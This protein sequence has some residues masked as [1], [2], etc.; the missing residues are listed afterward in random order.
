MVPPATG[1]EVLSVGFSSSTERARRRGCLSCGNLRGP[2]CD[3]ARACPKGR[4][5]GGVF[6]S[7]LR[8]LQNV[9]NYR[10]LLAERCTY[11]HNDCEGSP[12][13]H[14]PAD[15]Y[16]T[17]KYRGLYSVEY[18][19]PQQRGATNTWTTV[20]IKN[21]E[22]VRTEN[23]RRAPIHILRRRN[24]TTGRRRG[25]PFRAAS[26]RHWRTVALILDISAF[27]LTSS[28]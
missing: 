19:M 11:L 24:G 22:K 26:A 13:G 10:V 1:V 2:G 15:T 21:V 12:H 16:Q 25:R 17:D 20:V 28:L 3:S 8:N 18:I 5:G 9:K 27:S 23:K 14:S 7:S 6:W 4:D